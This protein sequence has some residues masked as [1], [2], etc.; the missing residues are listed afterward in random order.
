[1]LAEG[2]PLLRNPASRF[3]FVRERPGALMLYVDGEGFECHGDAAQFGE[4]LC[5]KD[6]LSVEPELANA[7][8]VIDLLA[9]LADQG[10][11]AFDTNG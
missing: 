8:A 6:R 11:V 1:M 9:D 10:S 3:A 7:D 5:A 4:Q 2:I